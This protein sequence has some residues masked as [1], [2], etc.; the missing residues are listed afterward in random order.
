VRWYDGIAILLVALGM[1]AGWMVLLVTSNKGRGWMVLAAVFAPA[2]FYVVARSGGS[3]EAAL[4]AGVI[5]GP[6]LAAGMVYVPRVR[7]VVVS[8]KEEEDL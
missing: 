2:C 7:D 8:W 1:M 6:L 4:A 3:P 5:G